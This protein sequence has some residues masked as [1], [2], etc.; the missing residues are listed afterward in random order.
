MSTGKEL[1]AKLPKPTSVSNL[2]PPINGF[3]VDKVMA[4]DFVDMKWLRCSTLNKLAIVDTESEVKKILD[5]IEEVEDFGDW[6]GY[7]S[8]CRPYEG[9]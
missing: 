6:V 9:K 5:D 1:K 4:G 2:L 8:I 7:F 3:I